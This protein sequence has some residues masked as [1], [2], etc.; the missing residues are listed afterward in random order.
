MAY[1]FNKQHGISVTLGSGFNQGAGADFDT[2]ALA[3]RF[4]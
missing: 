2:I 4:A 1:P 3:Y